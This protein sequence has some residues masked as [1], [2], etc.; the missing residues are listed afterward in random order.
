[1]L[2]KLILIAVCVLLN[3]PLIRAD[4]RPDKAWTKYLEGSWTY[5]ISD[6]TK[7]SAEWTYDADG[8]SMVGRFEEDDSTAVEIGGWQPD[9]KIVMVNGYGSKGG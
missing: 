6:G 3:T 9:T 8:Q 2:R 5:E 4:E 7:G 1:M